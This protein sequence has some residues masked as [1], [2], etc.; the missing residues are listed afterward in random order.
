[1]ASIQGDRT[2]SQI[3]NVGHNTRWTST[4]LDRGVTYY[5]SVQAIDN[6]F[7]GSG[8]SGEI[9]FTTNP[10]KAT[11]FTPGNRG[12]GAITWIDSNNDGQLDFNQGNLVINLNNLKVQRIIKQTSY[13]NL[14]LSQL[15]NKGFT[16]NGINLGD[17]FGFFSSAGD[18]NNDG[19]DDLIIGAPNADPNGIQNA[20]QSYVIFGK[21][22]S[23]PSNLDLSTLNGNN[24]FIINGIAA[25]DALGVS[26]SSGGDINQDGY[27]DLIIGAS[28]A[29]SSTGQSYVI[30]GKA[31]GFNSSL[32]L[33]TL[34]G[35]NGFIINGITA[36]DNSGFSVSNAGDLNNDGYDDIIIGASG[37]N[38]STGQNYVIF[39][40]A[41]GFNPS[42]NLS[43]LD[44]NNG[45]AI[46]GINGFNNSGYT[47]RSAGDVNN[48]SYDDIIIAAYDVN[49]SQGQG[50]VVFGKASGF[51]AS[52]DL[53]TLD[54][55]NG[56]TINGINATPTFFAFNVSG[57]GDVNNDGYDDII[58][59]AYSAN[60]NA[61]QSYIILGKAKFAASLDLANI[62]GKNG[63]IIDGIN[64]N[65]ASGISVSDG[66]D[67]N[68]D[69]FD[70]VII[71]SW[72][73][74][75][76]TGQSYVVF[77]T[78]IT[79]DSA[80]WGDLDNDGDLDLAL[81]GV[82]AK[83]ASFTKIYRNVN[84]NLQEVNTTLPSLTNSA[85]DWGD[86][87]NDGFVDLVFVGKTANGTPITRIYQ[88]NGKGNLTPKINLTGVSN[89]DVSWG[90]YNN[91]G[92]LD[93]LVTGKTGTGKS[94]TK[95]Y[96]NKGNNTFT[97][98]ANLLG[99]SNSSATWGD[100]N[101]DS[102]LDILLTGKPDTGNSITKVYQNDGKGVFVSKFDLTGISNGTGIWGDYDNDG[103]LDIAISGINN[104]GKNTVQ[105]YRGN[106]G[107]NG[108]FQLFLD[109]IPT[110][111]IKYDN[112]VQ[113]DYDDDGDL[114]LLLGSSKTGDTQV[115]ENQA[116]NLNTTPAAP[117]LLAPIITGNNVTLKWTRGTDQETSAKGLTYNLRVGTQ[118]GKGDIF[119]APVK[120]NGDLLLADLGNVNHN[121]KWT[122]NNLKNGTYYWSIQTVDS[123]LLGSSFAP[124]GSFAIQP[125]IS[126]EKSAIS[127]TEGDNGFVNVNLNVKLPAA[128]NK[129]VKV[130]Y[131]TI[132][133]SATG[134]QDYQEITGT[135][136]FK[137][138]EIS[139]QI[140]VK[141][142][143]D[144]LPEKTENFSVNLFN[145]INGI[146]NQTKAKLTI[147]SEKNDGV[148][149][150]PDIILSNL[151]APATVNWGKTIT[152]S[153]DVKNQGNGILSENWIHNIYLS[154][155]NK[156]DAG[157]RLLTTS[158]SSL[159]K[160]IAIQ[161]IKSYTQNLVIPNDIQGDKFLLLVAD[162][163]NVIKEKLENNN[164][165]SKAIKITKGN[166]YG[167]NNN[168]KI[169]GTN[170]NDYLVGL[171]GNDT[172][173]GNNG[174]D[175][176]SGGLGNDSLNGGLGKD[177]LLE[178]GNVNFTLTNTKLQGLGQDTLNSIEQVYLIGGTSNNTLNA[179]KFTLGGVTL[180][181]KGGADKLSGGTKNDILI[182]DA[183][184]DTLNGNNGNDTLTG[185]LGN[186]S[187]NGGLGK[188]LLIESG[189]VNFTLTNTQLQGLGQD[190]L[191]SIE[192]VY[193]IGGT[194][195]NTL[196]ATKFTL[197]GVTLNGGEGTDKLL[198]G[199][200]N[201]LLVGDIGNDTLT[202]G[203]GNDTLNGG[204]GGDILNGT[205]SNNGKGEIDILTGDKG[206]DKFILGSQQAFFYNDG[207]ATNAGKNDYALIKDFDKLEDAIQLKGKAINYLIGKSPITGISGRAI[208]LDTNN[209]KSLNANDELIAI[210]EGT[211]SLN[212]NAN[213]FVYV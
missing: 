160:P 66:G 4:T 168:D 36:S 207:V 95:V 47:V 103:F 128:S 42:L 9:K 7:T 22:S 195:N 104:N 17:F 3:G 118:P 120:Q 152:V 130:N 164:I 55:K 41:S 80:S 200:K 26:V 172:L 111:N 156:L 165:I 210:I 106:E 105:I 138:G 82:D 107:N 173:N 49:N 129:Q 19:Y 11:D 93:I 169:N 179:T 62:N 54:G 73:I 43:T 133:N 159:S 114:D 52:L 44:G 182:G 145:P 45:F 88:N 99:V 162:E 34:D 64:P 191:N 113:G 78:G 181:G 87:N 86:Y 76:F 177:L 2:I 10:F 1:M 178:S 203:L 51:N 16:I 28:G 148:P 171:G 137:P 109:Q 69:G 46:N 125:L 102:F 30:F 96:Q 98:K 74:N 189:D 139:K 193:L 84:G 97:E 150:K 21:A 121:I 57:A 20:G 18:L 14:K 142:L 61:G 29:N 174:N 100:Y 212:L 194:S 91:D 59:G 157:D 199:R 25:G 37:A 202:G 68:Q 167:T 166:F 13:N 90:D 158:N 185:G 192:Q 79:T 71:G 155:D 186:D 83:K 136:I 151:K 23:F 201:D 161:A 183:G 124:E 163:N 108:S 153:W 92:F 67:V 187:L 175:T 56:F 147:N 39:G 8:F 135:L 89:G 58:I 94:I 110:T 77:G 190:T 188:D 180:H 31:S 211:N 85:S 134:G 127:V 144:Y 48:D 205:G 149:I 33:S 116:H 15:T 63:F 5:A 70:D 50:Y 209:N 206:K 60:N 115:Y 122:L 101:N 38:S 81:V 132:S 170:K 176:L 141:V 72:V 131:Q 204:L 75:N 184:N 6:N 197:G 146:L 143:G 119:S 12:I 123:G 154:N 53:S 35:T 27:E 208:Y 65:D 213:Y 198:G 112:L 32:D 40:K 117:T 126:F 196:N 24:G 140:V